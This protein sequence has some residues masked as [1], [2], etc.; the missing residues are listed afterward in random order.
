VNCANSG[1]FTI[2]IS[3][4]TWLFC[5]ECIFQLPI[6]MSDSFVSFQ[7]RRMYAGVLLHTVCKRTVKMLRVWISCLTNTD[8]FD[9]VCRIFYFPCPLSS[10]LQISAT[11]VCTSTYLLTKFYRFRCYSLFQICR[12]LYV[13][14]SDWIWYS[15]S[16]DIDEV[17]VGVPHPFRRRVSIRYFDPSSSL[18]QRASFPFA[19]I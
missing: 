7:K 12:F 4:K 3:L 19:F 2:R 5:F 11:T 15:L 14:P 9:P 16:F 8:L 10:N 17:W 1:V 13:C 18:V 6:S